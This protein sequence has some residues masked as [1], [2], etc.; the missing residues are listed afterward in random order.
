MDVRRLKRKLKKRRFY[1]ENYRIQSF[2]FF[3]LWFLFLWKKSKFAKLKST[4]SALFRAFKIISALLITVVV[5]IST[6]IVER[7]R[8]TELVIELPMDRIDKPNV[9]NTDTPRTSNSPLSYLLFITSS[10]FQN[11]TEDTIYYSIY[12]TLEQLCRGSQILQRVHRPLHFKSQRRKRC[13]RSPVVPFTAVVIFI[14][15]G[16]FESKKSI[17]LSTITMLRTTVW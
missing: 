13:W 12:R 16:Y 7:H 1:E 4:I 5:D 15:T 14:Y 9:P 2:F 6:F 17:S 10:G 3:L 8:C 11:R